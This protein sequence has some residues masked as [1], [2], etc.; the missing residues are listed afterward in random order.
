MN[1]SGKVLIGV[2]T[3]VVIGATL[4]ILFAPDKGSDTRKKISKKGHDLA[5]DVK[6]K[7]NQFT[8]GVADKY[9][10]VKNEVSHLT[11][12]GKSKLDEM[13]AETRNAIK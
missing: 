11:D 5:D 1:S 2:L 9:E 4:G 10:N 7:F 12:F 3:G 6:K 13:K 8:E